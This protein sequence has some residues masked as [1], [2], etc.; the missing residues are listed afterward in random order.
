MR[1]QDASL[2]LKPRDPRPVCGAVA[3]VAVLASVLGTALLLPGPAG[4]GAIGIAGITAGDKRFGS[5]ERDSKAAHVRDLAGERWP[6]VSDEAPT[7]YAVWG[8]DATPQQALHIMNLIFRP[9]VTAGA[10][11]NFETIG[12]ARNDD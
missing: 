2:M 9:P 11:V 10:A 7:L 1:F 3:S 12:A 4:A 6:E 5:G 8:G